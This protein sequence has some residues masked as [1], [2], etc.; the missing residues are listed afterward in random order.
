MFDVTLSALSE[1]EA[2]PLYMRLYRHFRRMM[3]DGA[4]PEGAR[5][6][7]VRAAQQ[8][9]QVSKTTVESA[10]QLLLA[11][12]CIYSKPKS[13]FV[14]VGAAGAGEATAPETGTKR[15]LTAAASA[16]TAAPAEERMIDFHLLH[17]DPDSFPAK[18][19]RSA[20]GE[21]TTRYRALLHEYGDPQGERALREH[22]AHY[23]QQSRGVRCEPE[24]IVVGTGFSYSL[25]LIKQLLGGAGRVSFEQTSFAQVGSIFRQHGFDPVPVAL[26]DDA[27]LAQDQEEPSLQAVYVTPSHRQAGK[28]LTNDRKERLLGWAA[29]NGLYVIED[30]YDGEF[31]YGGKPVPALQA[32]DRHGAVIYVGTFSKAFTPALRMNYMVLPPRLAGRLDT[33][34]S[35]LSCPSR[36]DQLAMGVFMERG[37]WY[38][39]LK[40]IRKRYRAKRDLLC[41]LIERE[42]SP[43]V[44]VDAGSSG[45]QVELAAA[46]ELGGGERLI[47]LAR[48]A[49]VRVYGAQHEEGSRDGGTRLYAGFGSVTEEEMERGVRLLRKAWL[50]TGH[51]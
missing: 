41:R 11:E 39:H 35:L 21:A 6:P 42:L 15:R 47:A 5:L 29:A 8:Q 12:G 13:G 40:R 3:A 22:V 14:V 19:W 17:V 24:R 9:L 37:H 46:A 50:E 30:D 38:R 7:S 31:R 2:G 18:A 4:L 33:V 49:G 20:L 45:L 27:G 16:S 44:R 28:P 34:E 1:Q 43:F 23:L 26:F 48:Q 51:A 25:F 10:Y 36:M 32:A